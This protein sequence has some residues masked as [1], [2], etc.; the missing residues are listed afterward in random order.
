MMELNILETECPKN[1][2]SQGEAVLQGKE[3][4][5][6]KISHPRVEKLYANRSIV[7]LLKDWN[8]E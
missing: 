1:S 6:E 5:C 3:H 2:D 8:L 4:V 7:Y